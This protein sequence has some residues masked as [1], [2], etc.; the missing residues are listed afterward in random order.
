MKKVLFESQIDLEKKKKDFSIYSRSE[1]KQCKTQVHK[2]FTY[3]VAQAK[4]ENP[5][6]KAPVVFIQKTF[7]TK[8]GVEGFNFHVKGYFHIHHNDVL[9]KV[10]FHHN[11]DIKIKWK[12]KDFSPQK[13]ASLT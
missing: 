9:L 10:F 12:I 7:D 11:L 4:E 8:K 3:V 5:E 13:S 6:A 1:D 2:S